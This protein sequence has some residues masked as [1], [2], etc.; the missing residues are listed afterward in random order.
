MNT[1]FLTTDSPR[2]DEVTAHIQKI[3]HETYGAKIKNFAPL[4]V[5]SFN[6]EGKIICAAGIRTK[7]DGFFSDTY[8]NND[9]SSAILMRTGRF[10]DT[11]EIMEVV[12]LASTTP[13]PVLAMM[14]KVVQWG[15]DHGKTLGLFT[16]TAKLRNLLGRANLSYTLLSP[17]SPARVDN[18]A[19]WGSYYDTDPCVCFFSEKFCAPATL[20]PRNRKAAGLL[21]SGGGM[22]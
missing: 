20:S 12:S 8:L 15:R 19:D 18:P 2:Y 10:V 14:D 22:V 16:A 3:Y 6:T 7:A 17:A 9:L 5:A 21:V 1:E 4:L 13:F 11:A